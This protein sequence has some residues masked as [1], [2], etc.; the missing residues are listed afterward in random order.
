MS[1]LAQYWKD[2][3]LNFSTVFF[4]NLCTVSENY[5]WH[6]TKLRDHDWTKAWLTTDLRRCFTVM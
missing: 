6:N 5:I 3:I 2:N 4:I 1:T